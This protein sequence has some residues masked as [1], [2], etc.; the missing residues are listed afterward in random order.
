[1]KSC[2]APPKSILCAAEIGVTVNDGTGWPS[3]GQQPHSP[4]P[5]TRSAAHRWALIG[6]TLGLGRGQGRHP[7]VDLRVE[8]GGTAARVPGR[9]IAKRE[10][11]LHATMRS[12]RPAGAGE[13][14]GL[15]WSAS[16]G[17]DCAL[18][19]DHSCFADR[20]GR[21]PRYKNVCPSRPR[22]AHGSVPR[23][24][25]T[26][27]WPPSSTSRPR[28]SCRA[29]ACW[30]AL[31]RGWGAGS[32]W[33]APRPGSAKRPCWATGPGAAAGQPRGCRW[34]PVTMTRRD[35]GDMSSRRWSGCAPGPARR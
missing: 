18:L 35:S 1:L 8:S 19:W 25:G 34:M 20:H 28:V 11:A 16:S 15:A 24:S 21:L 32:P 26:C 13:P 12:K 17:L 3:A 6:S 22:P 23:R 27:W 7:E 31:P 33:S 4:H 29:P 10:H 9:I 2:C 5:R 14:S 30:S